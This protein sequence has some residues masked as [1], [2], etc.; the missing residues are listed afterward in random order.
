ML[1][2]H[3]TQDQ[4]DRLFSS[5]KGPNKLERMTGLQVLKQLTNK[6]DK[7]GPTS[8]QLSLL[9]TMRLSVWIDKTVNTVKIMGLA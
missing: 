4:Y 8:S 9:Q 3:G 6:S 5:V 7:M 2:L 1:P